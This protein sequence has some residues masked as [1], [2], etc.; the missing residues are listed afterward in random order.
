MPRD[1]G[2]SGWQLHHGLAEKRKISRHILALGLGQQMVITPGLTLQPRY[3]GLSVLPTHIDYWSLAAAPIRIGGLVAFA[4][5]V[6]DAGIPF[7]KGH[8]EPAD[9]EWPRKRHA[10]LWAFNVKANWRRS[11]SHDRDPSEAGLAVRHSQ[12]RGKFTIERVFVFV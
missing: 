9:R 2:S 11:A 8:R 10:M 3:V 4:A 12:Q 1:G 7:V 5:A 6:G